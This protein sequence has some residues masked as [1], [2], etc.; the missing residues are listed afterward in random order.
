MA[1]ARSW[2]AAALSRDEARAGEAVLLR[3]QAALPVV[4][5]VGSLGLAVDS[6][7][8]AHALDEGRRQ[9]AAA[10]DERLQLLAGQ[11][12]DLEP[13]LGGGCLEVAIGERRVEGAAQGRDGRV[14]QAG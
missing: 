9:A 14:G 11:R 12:I 8:A 5:G 3:Q 13:R 6:D 2:R 1:D 7:Q 4:S 10:G